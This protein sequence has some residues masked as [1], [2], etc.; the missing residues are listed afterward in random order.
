MKTPHYAFTTLA[1]ALA[2]LMT[3]LAAPIVHAQSGFDGGVSK[4]QT[5]REKRAARLAKQ[6]GETASKTGRKDEVAEAAPLFPEATRQQPE[7]KASRD[8][9]KDLQE[10]QETYQSGDTAATIAAAEKIVSK[11]SANAYDKSFA[12]QMA[13]TAAAQAK[14]DAKAADY[15]QRALAS[16]GLDNNNH[17]QVMYNLAATQY[18]LKQYS[19][20]LKTLDRFMSETKS[21]KPEHMNLRGALLTNLKRYDEAAK[22]YQDLMAKHPGNQEYLMN[23]IAAYQQAGE[24]DK[25]AALLSQAQAKGGL[26]DPNQYRALYVTYINGDKLDQAVKTIDEGI[27]KGIIKPSPELARD[28]MVLGQKAYYAEDDATAIEMYKRAA[29]MATDGEAALN[30]AKIYASDGKTAQASAAAKQALAKGV[31]DTAAAKK[32]AGSGD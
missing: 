9:L 18:G 31:K 11:D 16:N 32:L 17:Y 10:L 28:Y 30:L 23:A 21:D 25:A 1:I 7:A 29:P 2:A 27:A 13:G 14:D 8:S 6:N 15:F 24:E 20:A 22:L 12:Y 26:T 3:T 19:P 5:M 4:P